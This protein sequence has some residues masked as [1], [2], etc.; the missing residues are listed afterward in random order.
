VLFRSLKA[1]NSEE[2]ISAN[3]ENNFFI[4]V[5]D[6]YSISEILFLKEGKSIVPLQNTLSIINN[7]P[8]TDNTFSFLI[9]NASSLAEEK[10]DLSISDFLSKYIFP[11]EKS[12]IKYE[13]NSFQ[14]SLKEEV[15]CLKTYSQQV[16][17]DLKNNTNEFI[18]NIISQ[19]SIKNFQDSINEEEWRKVLNNIDLI[20]EQQFGGNDSAFFDLKTINWDLI[21]QEI[22]KCITDN[23]TRENVV[24]ILNLL[25]NKLVFGTP[26]A[27]QLPP[28]P[29]LRFPLIKFPTIPHPQ[30]I[31]SSFY[32]SF[33]DTIIQ[34]RSDI[35]FTFIR[36]INDFALKCGNNVDP[37]DIG[38]EKAKDLLDD[39]QGAAS[40]AL[41]SS[42][43][44][45]ENEEKQLLINEIKI[46][47]DNVAENLTKNEMLT[48][49]VGSPSKETLQIVKK[50]IN[51][52]ELN[53]E[54]VILPIKLG[55]LKPKTSS[56]TTTDTSLISL[57][58]ENKEDAVARSENN[59]VILSDKKVI[60][61]F[62]KFD[63]NIKND[64]LNDYLNRNN[65]TN[66]PNLLCLDTTV[67]N[68]NIKKSLA[69]KGLSER[70]ALIEINRKDDEIKKAIN[71]LSKTLSL[72]DKEFVKQ[73]NI[74]CVKNPDGSITPGISDKVGIP[75]AFKIS[76]DN[77]IEDMYNNF[78]ISYDKEVPRWFLN[79][80]QKDFTQSATPEQNKVKNIFIKTIQQQLQNSSSFSSSF[81]D[82]SEQN[83][84]TTKIPPYYYSNDLQ[85]KKINNP[86][87]ILTNFYSFS[88]DIF[89]RTNV[90]YIK[91]QNFISGVIVNNDFSSSYSGTIFGI[92][93]IDDNLIKNR[94]IFYKTPEYFNFFEKIHLTA[95]SYDFLRTQKDYYNKIKTHN[96]LVEK[97]FKAPLSASYAFQTE[98]SGSS[99]LLS[100]NLN[101]LL[102]RKQKK[103]LK[104]DKCNIKDK[105]LINLE[106]VKKDIL[107]ISNENSC[108]LPDVND[109]GVKNPSVVDNANFNAAVKLLMRVY[110][111]DFNFK[112]LPLSHFLSTLN[113]NSLYSVFYSLFFK[114]LEKIIG[115]IFV[116]K[117]KKQLIKDFLKIEDEIQ[118]E[119]SILDE[120]I[121]Q[122]AFRFAFEKNFK[123]VNRNILS[124]IRDDINAKN[125]FLAGKTFIFN[126]QEEI[127]YEKNYKTYLD[128]IFDNIVT[129]KFGLGAEIEQTQGNQV[130]A[131]G[132]RGFSQST[133]SGTPTQQ[134]ELKLT[135]NNIAITQKQADLLPFCFIKN[136][137]KLIFKILNNN[138]FKAD[139]VPATFVEANSIDLYQI[140]YSENY[141]Y[142]ED[143]VFKK[144]FY[145]FFSS[146]VPLE[147]I[148][149][150]QIA[151]L[152]LSIS[153]IEKITSSFDGSKKA[154]K[155]V[156]DI[157]ESA[158]DYKK[159]LEND[160]L[161]EAMAKLSILFKTPEFI[162]K[163]LAETTDPNVAI[164]SNISKAYEAAVLLSEMA[165]VQIPVKKL[166]IFAISP[167]VAATGVIPI[168]P[169]GF[170]SIALS[171]KDISI[172]LE[173][174]I[175][176]EDDE[177]C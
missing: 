139:V 92:P 79:A 125:V 177:S 147:E 34:L 60:F 90:N 20:S 136:D 42:G 135:I 78:D 121:M 53:G 23:E 2:T 15:D 77:L 96:R 140:E 157:I 168:T 158:N 119:T 127:L 69:D 122:N 27:C 138:F 163:G 61:L 17:I 41:E 105:R 29:Q 150:S 86:I 88:N 114:D 148:F 87:T 104:Q 159:P 52:L 170:I 142:K 108:V 116:E 8:A 32:Q 49:F 56:N 156:Y 134:Q 45:T 3:E 143:S 18:N 44:P 76:S 100:Y 50:Q 169:Q 30:S 51:L 162:I 111:I 151:I 65:I 167:L 171:L 25:K 73:P 39:F 113:S 36:S 115:S 68:E 83:N 155:S 37:S 101:P 12:Q 70:D 46:V 124:L 95:S 137:N 107:I 74:N 21:I 165:G 59:T 145:A 66:N 172:D 4:L 174:S 173:Q 9:C 99:K 16:V 152:L 161:E 13:E 35:I 98:A 72:M 10:E 91:D 62:K 84:F 55:V 144:L 31:V 160:G 67:L 54:I 6:K 19:E 28:P 89:Y 63:K 33:T 38:K 131:V 57:I 132:A 141:D 106:D 110:A 175:A 154:L 118:I 71:Q 22:T 166:P 40:D 11:T 153:S 1:A 64:V 43:I 24:A 5:F 164:S 133:L 80:T 120:K 14:K 97:L 176:K 112:L 7:E 48:L 82:S 109:D 58:S 85:E 93:L 117:L 26:I 81:F 75:E 123:E 128:F 94:N 146:C 129:V 149:T 47:I 103:L 126:Q 130:E 102:T